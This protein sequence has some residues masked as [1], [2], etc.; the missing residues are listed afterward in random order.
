MYRSAHGQIR[1]I[2]VLEL[3]N[4][5]V[6]RASDWNPAFCQPHQASNKLTAAYSQTPHYTLLTDNA[7]VISK[8]AKKYHNTV[9]VND[10]AVFDWNAMFLFDFRGVNEDPAH[11]VFTKGLFVQEGQGVTF[12]LLLLGFLL[13]ALERQHVI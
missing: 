6:L 13:R 4:T 10:V 1:Q 2:A 9:G 11:P 5:C 12:R 8:Q 7:I 3:K